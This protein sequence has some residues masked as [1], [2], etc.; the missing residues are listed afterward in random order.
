MEQEG[1][2]EKEQEWG[3]SRNSDFERKKEVMVD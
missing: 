3:Y 1:G 2:K